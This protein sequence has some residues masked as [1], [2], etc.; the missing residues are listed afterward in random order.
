M[1][2]EIGVAGGLAG[3]P[4]QSRSRPHSVSIWPGSRR[5]KQRSFNEGYTD[6]HNVEAG[7]G[8]VLASRIWTPCARGIQYPRMRSTA[9]TH[10]RKRAR[11]SHTSVRVNAQR[12]RA[13]MR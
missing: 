8:P 6:T 5:P 4:I 1:V 9:I 13:P 11:P 2:D 12:I 7:K 10:R 3:A